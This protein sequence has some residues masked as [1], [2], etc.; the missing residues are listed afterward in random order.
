MNEL[1]HVF[2]VLILSFFLAMRLPYFLSCCLGM[3]LLNNDPHLVALLIS[4]TL[5]LWIMR[6]HHPFLLYT[7]P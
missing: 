7:R 1:I 3:E 6:R 2:S 5:P 4:L